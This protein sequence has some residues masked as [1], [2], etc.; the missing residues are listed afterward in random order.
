[1]F[2]SEKLICRFKAEENTF[3]YDDKG[4]YSSADTTV[5]AL[6]SKGKKQFSTKY[7]LALLNSKLLSFYFKSY[8]KLMDYRYE[9]YPGRLAG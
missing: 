2:D 3:C 8:G 1:M 7:L 5:V 4:F 6:N 9:Y